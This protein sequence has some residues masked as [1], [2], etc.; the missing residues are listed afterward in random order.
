MLAAISSF[1]AFSVGALVPLLPWLL[2]VPR[3]DVAVLLTLVALF[4]CGAVVS[5]V[6]SRTWW[7][8]GL[9]QVALGGAAAAATY[10]L[11]AAVGV[12]LG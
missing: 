12:G 5:R 11:G 4:A 7:Y 1:L 10:G 2:G 9:R 3:L 8:A 6:T